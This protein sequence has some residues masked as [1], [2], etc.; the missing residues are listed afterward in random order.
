MLREALLPLFL[1]VS[2]PASHLDDPIRVQAW[3]EDGVAMLFPSASGSSFRLGS[4]DP[5]A[6]MGLTIEK[7]LHA[8]ADQEGPWRFWNLPSYSLQYAS[9]GMGWT[10]RLH[11]HA[12][13]GTQHFTWKNQQGHLS[14]PAD[15]RNMEFTAYVRVHE[16]LDPKRAAITLKV[17]GGRHTSAQPDLASGV[18]MTFQPARQGVVSRF[19][20]ELVHP[21]YDYVPLRPLFPAAL[22]EEAWYGLKLVCWN[23]TDQPARA[24]FRLYVDTDPFQRSTGCLSNQWRL[25][26]EYMDEEGKSSGQY[27]K[28]VDWGGWE[29]TLRTDGF[30]EIDFALISLREIIPP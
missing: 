21:N 15:L 14:G 12:S 17:R 9:G 7:G 19:G 30:R 2:G 25:L 20:K 3:D 28:L 16:I 10:S 1:W 24:V 4:S 23:T 29:T 18:M 8:K 26:S 27:T 5:N 6:T 22:R 11:L 13:G